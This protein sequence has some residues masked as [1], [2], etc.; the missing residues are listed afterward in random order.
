MIVLINCGGSGSRLWP[1]S[2]PDYPKHL[3]KIEGSDGDGTLL[4]NTY[5]RV[6]DIAEKVYF[7]TEEG[8]AHHVQE[9]LKGVS[10]EQIIVEPARRGTASCIIYALDYIREKYDKDAPLVFLNADHV[11]HDHGAFQ[12]A[13]VHATKASSR[14][15]TIAF[16]GIKPTYPSSGFG[17]IEKGKKISKNGEKDVHE[18]ASFKEKPDV[19]TAIKF[20]REGKYYWNTGNYA[21]SLSV[22]IKAMK[23]DMTD[24]YEAYNALQTAKDNET[25]RKIYLGFE[26]NSMEYALLEK[27][28]RLLVV[29]GAFDWIDI[30]SYQDLHTISHQ[31]SDGNAAQ[32]NNIAISKVTNSF[33]RN[34][35]NQKVGVVGV[36]NIAVVVTDEG[37]VVTNRNTSQN[38]KEIVKILLKNKSKNKE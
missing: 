37:I 29:P 9:Q 7:I 6:K 24:L 36:D 30:G 34:D 8:H 20:I 15:G 13:V 3:L 31:D 32:G 35:T 14:H 33:I 18:V 11:I 4:Q 22:W 1:L 27:A 26:N 21:A 5:A 38:V 12:E 17:Y 16:F 28:K 23:S 2:T 19:E 25:K 10:N